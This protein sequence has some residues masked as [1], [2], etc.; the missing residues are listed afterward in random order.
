MPERGADKAIPQE[1]PLEGKYANHFNVGF[2][3]NEV[4]VDFGQAFTDRSGAV[5]HTRIVM[6]PA[7]ARALQAMLREST[8]QSDAGLRMDGES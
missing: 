7:S 8:G 1:A 5:V 4:V 2:N 3:D 6:S